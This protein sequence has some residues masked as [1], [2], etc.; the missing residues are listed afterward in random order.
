MERPTVNAV[1]DYLLEKKVT[2]ENASKTLA[3]IA[4]GWPE[5]ES[6]RCR[7]NH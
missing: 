7:S 5:K 3:M 6:A 1:E 4:A 2:P